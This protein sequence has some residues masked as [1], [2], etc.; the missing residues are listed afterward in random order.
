MWVD[1][2][3]SSKSKDEL[4]KDIARFVVLKGYLQ[5]KYAPR[6]KIWQE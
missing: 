6:R 3:E 5:L 4:G 2:D 1:D